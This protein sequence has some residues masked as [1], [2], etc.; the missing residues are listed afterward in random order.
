MLS[1][2]TAF[3]NCPRDHISRVD[4]SRCGHQVR[5]KRDP[6][7]SD[8]RVAGKRPIGNPIPFSVDTS[9]GTPLSVEVDIT[10]L[11]QANWGDG[12]P[13]RI[14]LQGKG[15]ETFGFASKEFFEAGMEA[16]LIV[17]LGAPITDTPAP[18]LRT[19]TLTPTST[20]YEEVLA[21]LILKLWP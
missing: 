6:R 20:L 21:P 18:V 17:T 14:A 2:L 15:P 4:P 3:V 19:A 9:Q 12:E 10:A 5:L 11:V 8:L 13:I 1:D 7:Q 16:K